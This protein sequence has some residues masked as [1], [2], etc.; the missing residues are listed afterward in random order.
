[1]VGIGALFTLARFSEAFLVLRAQQLGL[2]L[3]EV[4]MVLMVMS[5]VYAAS[6]YPA[7]VATDRLGRRGMLIAGLVVLVAADIVLSA[8]HSPAQALGGAALWGLHMGLTQGLLSKLVADTGP[9]D[10]RGTAFGV[11]NLVSGGA[12]LLASLTAGALWSVWGAPATFAVGA[13][14]ASLAVLAL[15][16][17]RRAAPFP[18]L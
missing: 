11:F 2:A 15:S 18:N 7:G 17:G 12:L 1:M 6:A 9:R 3:G 16:L 4:P 5:L 13:V 14:L 10:L 8:A